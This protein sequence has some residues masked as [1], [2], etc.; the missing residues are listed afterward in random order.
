MW[1]APHQ[2]GAISMRSSKKANHEAVHLRKRAFLPS[3]R[4]TLGVSRRL[5]DAKS[6]ANRRERRWNWHRI[7]Y[8]VKINDLTGG[9]RSHPR[10]GLSP[11]FPGYGNF[12]REFFE[13]RSVLGLE[14]RLYRRCCGDLGPNSRG[15]SRGNF[16]TEQGIRNPLQGLSR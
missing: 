15:G 1:F 7:K 8:A 2:F 4:A 6:G 11:K 9:G 3:L 10:T 12:C 14:A 13:F 16:S 5:S